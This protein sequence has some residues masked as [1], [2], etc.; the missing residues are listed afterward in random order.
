VSWTIVSL[1]ILAYVW[2]SLYRAI[3]KE[4]KIKPVVWAVVVILAIGMMI[5]AGNL[6]QWGKGSWALIFDRPQMQDQNK[7]L[8]SEVFPFKE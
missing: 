5:P 6:T 8:Y 3:R 7:P 1:L 2:Y 4:G